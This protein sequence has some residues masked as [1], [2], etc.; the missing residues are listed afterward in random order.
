MIVQAFNKHDT[1]SVTQWGGVALIIRGKW[2]S[3]ASDYQVDSNGLGRWAAALISGRHN[4]KTWVIVT[5]M[6]NTEGQAE[7]IFSQH[8]RYLQHSKDMRDLFLVL[9]FDQDLE[10]NWFMGNGGCHHRW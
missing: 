3:R 4:C 8:E 7:S 1:G 5:Y 9:A 6:P 10:N 2:V